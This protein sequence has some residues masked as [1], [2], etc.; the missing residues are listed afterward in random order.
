M[1]GHLSNPGHSYR[2]AF[3]FLLFSLNAQ[4]IFEFHRTLLIEYYWNFFNVEY[5]YIYMYIKCV[6]IFYVK[7]LSRYI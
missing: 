2:Y 5:T 1:L 4:R 6:H 3:L 7:K